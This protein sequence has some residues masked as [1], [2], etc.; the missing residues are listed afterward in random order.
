MPEN[1]RFERAEA[2]S[3]LCRPKR[4]ARVEKSRQRIEERRRRL[5]AA[6]RENLQRRKEQARARQ[7]EAVTAD[8]MS[9]KVS[10]E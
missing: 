10:S 2:M 8:E 1:H 4:P 7:A 9:P 6:L 3:E 5:A